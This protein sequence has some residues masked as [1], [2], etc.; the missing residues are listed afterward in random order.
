MSFIITVDVTVP[1]RT[2][3]TIG[4]L[5]ANTTCFLQ[6]IP[7][8]RDRCKLRVMVPPTFQRLYNG[9]R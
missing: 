6:K 4:N 2:K 1:L 7:S 5:V 3:C 9:I 8:A